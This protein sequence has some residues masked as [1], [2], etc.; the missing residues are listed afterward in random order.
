MKIRV[1]GQVFVAMT[2]IGVNLTACGPSKVAQCKA[3]SH[4]MNQVAGLSKDF[5]LVEKALVSKRSQIKGIKD[6]HKIVQDSA[7][8]VTIL[9][10]TSSSN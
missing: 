10:T 3:L 9:V 2:L 7:E 8:K 4:E 6:F 5:D 1:F